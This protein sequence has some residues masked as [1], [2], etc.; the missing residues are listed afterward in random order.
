MKPEIKR[1]LRKVIRGA[2]SL[3]EYSAYPKVETVMRLLQYLESKIPGMDGIEFFE[4]LMNLPLED[5]E[6]FLKNKHL[7]L[8]HITAASTAAAI[9]KAFR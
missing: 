6:M 7:T 4:T 9:E 8:E 5:L 1:A 3:K 2:I